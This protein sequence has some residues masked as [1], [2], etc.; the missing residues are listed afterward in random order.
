MTT[1]EADLTPEEYAKLVNRAKSEGISL[2]KLVRNVILRFLKSENIN[3]EDPFFKVVVDGPPNDDAATKH[4][5][6]LYG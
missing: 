6:Y 5:Q 3:P 4:D 1:V 2:R